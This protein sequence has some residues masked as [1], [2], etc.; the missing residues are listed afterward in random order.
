M[1]INLGNIVSVDGKSVGNGIASGLDSAALIEALTN[2]RRIPAV[3]LEDTVKLNDEKTT[4]FSSFRTLMDRLQT[5]VD[6][7][8]NPPGFN[9]NDANLFDYRKTALTTNSGSA[10]SSFLSVSADPGANTGDY[11]VAIGQLATNRQERSGSFASQSTSLTD[12]ASTNAAGR[13][14]AGSFQFASTLAVN[15]GSTTDT[16][17]ALTTADY[18]VNGAS[19]ASILTAGGIENITAI[20]A[21]GAKGLAGSVGNITGTFSVSPT[22]SVDLSVTIGGAVFTSN[23]IATNDSEAGAITSL[24]FTANEPA[25]GE[26]ITLGGATYTFGT[27]GVASSGAVIETGANLAETLTNIQAHLSSVDGQ[28]VHA[29]VDNF[30][31]TVDGNSIVATSDTAGDADDA[32]DFSTNVAGA[33]VGDTAGNYGGIAAG[34][35]ITFTDAA[36][37]T[38]FTLTVGSAFSI[39]NDITNVD[40]FI[41]G[42]EADISGQTIL[43]NRALTNFTTAEIPTGSPLDG[44]TSANIILTSGSFGSST[45]AAGDITGFTVTRNGADNNDISVTINDVVYS[46][47]GLADTL[48][49]NITLTGADGKQLAINLGDAG[50]SFNIAD[51]AAAAEL[52]NAFDYA[53]GTK[54]LTTFTISEGDS[55]I[56]IEANINALSS[57]SGVSAS[58]IK[59]SDSDF[60]LTFQAQKVGLD[61]SFNVVDYSNVLNA[62]TG[63]GSDGIELSTTQSAQDSFISVNDIVVQRSSNSISDVISDITFNLLQVTES[64]TSQAG[65]DAIGT[66]IE[67]KA[68]VSNDTTTVESGIL[69]FIN[70]YN[71]FRVFVAEQ[72]QRDDEGK[73]LEGSVLGEDTTLNTLVLQVAAEITK[74]V[75]GVS[76]SD[77]SSLGSIGIT[78]DNFDGDADN[79]ATN[80]ILTYD[81]NDLQNAL[82][83]NFDSVRELFEYS[84]T[85]NS[86]D[87]SL[88][89]KSNNTTLTDYQLDID[90]SRTGSEVRVLDADGIFLFNAETTQI[91]SSGYTITGPADSTLEGLQLIYSGDGTDIITVGSSAGIAD[92][93]FNTFEAYTEDDGLLDTAVK[94]LKDENDDLEV[95][96]ADIDAL[97]AQYRQRL[98]E[99]YTAL[100]TAI[101]KVNSI[102]D[103]LTAQDEAANA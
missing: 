8:R 63:D 58:I 102:I 37:D 71:E 96:I 60:R 103:L 61:N 54:D 35:V 88:F 25:V 82:A 10:A 7:L 15:V 92:R 69:N 57:S 76:N 19:A 74:S 81:P 42:L 26:T 49:S 2:A 38:S 22:N 83:N 99:Q 33:A 62:G 56:D 4:A 20:S 45:G 91:S 100:E 48:N 47:T 21:D 85:A 46:T 27:N 29:D 73:L 23:S 1:S 36:G 40:S 79:V 75:S 24:D 66:E 13:F 95:D 11:E 50:A 68:N 28:T 31:Y 72:S 64:F 30:T 9:N 43:Q 70:T 41:T 65:F 101:T 53:F 52:Q 39:D 5:S 78:L 67:V 17:V 16:T 12:A 87:L 32:I 86:S 89:S 84:F 14:S 93:L 90:T 98:I 34:Q 55:L 97:I 3:R 77:F 18:S 6:F 51:S 59:V 94:N 44:L 80:N